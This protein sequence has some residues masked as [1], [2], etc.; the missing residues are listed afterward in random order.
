MQFLSSEQMRLW[1]RRAIAERGIAGLTLMNRA[2]AAV[3]GVVARL[4]RIHGGT[5]V[6]LVAGKGNNGGDALVA[7]R[8]LQAE[9]IRAQVLLTCTPDTLRGDALLAMEQLRMAGVPFRILA[10]EAAW[11]ALDDID[12]LLDGVVVDGLLGTGSAGCSAGCGGC[13]H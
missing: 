11:L 6:V 13:S 8:C 10:D 9:G 2:G 4:L 1:D 12:P 7:A 5:R 3:A